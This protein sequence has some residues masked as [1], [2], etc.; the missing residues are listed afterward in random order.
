M[1]IL[2]IANSI[3][4]AEP[5]VTGGE[6]RFI[7]L[8]KCWSKKGYEIHLMSGKA[9]KVLCEKMGLPVT[10]HSIS[11]SPNIGRLEI[12]AVF[13]KMLFHLPALLFSFKEGIVYS[14]SEQIY[15]VFPGFLL[16]LFR[17]SK[18][19]FGVVTHWLPPALFWKRKN[20]NFLFSLMFLISERLGLL[21]ANLNAD[22]LLPVSEDTLSALK[23]SIFNRKPA[24][25]VLCGVNFDEINSY[26]PEREEK[27]YDAVFMKRLQRTKGI[28]DLVEIWAELMKVKPDAKLLVIGEGIDGEEARKMSTDKGLD[29]NIEFAGVIYDPAE[30]FKKMWQSK[31]F[32]LPSY[33]ENW[34]IVIGE[35]MAAGIPVVCYDLKELRAVWEDNV[36]Y[37]KTG[38]KKDLLDKVMYLLENEPERAKMAQKAREFVKKYSWNKIADTELSLILGI[39]P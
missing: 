36:I 24:H 30:K 28:L 38:D 34:A 32:V 27:K 35:A 10:L 31:V 4:G 21:F 16:K 18:I 37:A 14:G 7:E 12:I 22:V 5:G 1:K 13:F 29:K 3:V 2:I 9:G 15:D 33:E 25:F 11:N 8:A 6:S 23:T 20:S 26:F 39:N 19:R 17:P